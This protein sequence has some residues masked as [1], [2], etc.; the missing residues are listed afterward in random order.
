MQS[1]GSGDRIHPQG[2]HLESQLRE[3][4]QGHQPNFMS[5]S[6]LELTKKS[7]IHS[8]KPSDR[9]LVLCTIGSH[10]PAQVPSSHC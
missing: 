6:G 2:L 5:S 7:L 8:K 4:L 1:G 9:T 10:A 3:E